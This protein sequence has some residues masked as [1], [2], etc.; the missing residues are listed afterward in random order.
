MSRVP[1][2]LPLGRVFAALRAIHLQTTFESQKFL[3]SNISI[4]QMRKDSSEMLGS[5][6]KTT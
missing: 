5:L 4:L 3:L 6:P 1:S 2:S